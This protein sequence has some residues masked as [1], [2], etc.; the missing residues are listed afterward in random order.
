[1]VS[2]SDWLPMIIAT[3]AWS[4]PIGESSASRR[5]LYPKAADTATVHHAAC[6]RN[7]SS[8]ECRLGQKVVP[9]RA[10][11]GSRHRHCSRPGRQEAGNVPIIPQ[12]RS[13]DNV[14]DEPVLQLLQAILQCQLLLLHTLDL[15][16]IAA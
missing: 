6:S 5:S 16:R 13:G 2:Q 12:R 9:E 8:L 14:G 1:M 15:Q 11:S 10:F 7:R 4:T 3:S